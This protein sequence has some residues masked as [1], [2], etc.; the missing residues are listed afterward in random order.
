MFH[1]LFKFVVIYNGYTVPDWLEHMQLEYRVPTTTEAQYK[2][3]EF[4]LFSYLFHYDIM[5]RW[6]EFCASTL[7][8]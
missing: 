7:H 8:I 1:S 5:K 4:E 2:Q 3:R 6:L